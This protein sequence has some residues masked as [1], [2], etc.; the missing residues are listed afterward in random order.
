MGLEKNKQVKIE[1]E[2]IEHWTDLWFTDTKRYGYV[3]VSNLGNGYKKSYGANNIE[4]MITDSMG[5]EERYISLNAFSFGSRREED[6]KQLRNI[7]VD[8]DQYKVM[9]DGMGDL[10]ALKDESVRKKLHDKPMSVESY[11]ETDRSEEGLRP[12]TVGEGIDRI[13]NLVERGIIPEPNLVLTSRG[14]Q[15]FYSIK[16]GAATEIDWLYKYINDQFVEK[17]KDLNSDP[18][19]HAI[20]GARR[21]PGS[22]NARDGSEVKWEIWND[23]PYTLE[24]L[25]RYCVPIK[26]LKKSKKKKKAK[27]Y[28][29]IDKNE[30]DRLEGIYAQNYTRVLDLE[31]LIELRKGDMTGM[32]NKL[33]YVYSFHFTLYNRNFDEL[34]KRMRSVL[35]RIHSKDREKIT[36]RAF[37]K[38]L[39][40]AYESA[41]RYFSHLK[42]NGYKKFGTT[43][44]GIIKPYRSVN[45]IKMFE[46]SEVEQQSMRDIVGKEEKKRRDMLRKREERGSTSREEYNKGRKMSKEEKIEKLRGI[47][48]E[49][50]SLTN[51]QIAEMI[52]VTGKY[53]GNL[54]KEL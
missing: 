1:R 14:I 19:A 22:V 49:D 33:L 29:F 40:S 16:H 38:T 20:T 27:V 41:M 28:D 23:E 24:E 18:R 53:I 48:K 47:L 32:R 34:E 46:L 17:T 15:I 51:K 6:L 13:N 30:K 12:M 7:C 31:N 2:K 4:E 21:M 50:P 26:K 3:E 43:A 36:D 42:E 5:I 10:E 8:I 45:L 39:L 54:K 11:L 37:E 25:S 9:V 44:D 35:D 52:G